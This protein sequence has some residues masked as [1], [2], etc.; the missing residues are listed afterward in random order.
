MPVSPRKV[1]LIGDVGEKIPGYYHIGDEAMFCQNESLYQHAGD[2]QVTRMTWSEFDPAGSAHARLWEMPVGTAGEHEIGRILNSARW[3][4]KLPFLQT[5]EPL[6]GYVELVRRQALIHISGGGNLNSLYPLELYARALIIHLAREFRIPVLVTGQTLGPLTDP[7]D[8]AVLA[9]ALN[10]CRV[11]TLRDRRESLRLVHELRVTNPRVSVEL[12]DAFFLDGVSF[13]SLAPL[14]LPSNNENTCRVGVSI[15]PADEPLVEEISRA[16]NLLAAQ[17]SFEFYFIPHLLAANDATQDV[18]MMRTIACRL[19][20]TV[21]FRIVTRK[22]LIEHPEPRKEKIVKGLT[23]AMDVVITTRYHGLVFAL[24][25]G[26]PALAINLDGYYETKNCG[27]LDLIFE[28][29]DDYA[30]AGAALTGTRLAER[31]MWLQGNRALIRSN[32]E[33]RRTAAREMQELNLTLAN[34]LLDA[35]SDFSARELR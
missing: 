20:P 27:L 12:D 4:K 7:T 30:L 25:S 24:S 8:R 21:S 11:L 16:L 13:D 32:L 3:Y 1:L 14:F 33:T 22:D 10:A 28:S 9:K 17:Q 2:F 5:P 23:A 29:S 18:A 26:V 35:P 31:V 19:D 34:S 6:R 15:Q